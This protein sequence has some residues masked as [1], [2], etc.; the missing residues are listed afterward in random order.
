MN[1]KDEMDRKTFELF[2]IGILAFIIIMAFPLL[3]AI[4][5]NKDTEETKAPIV[6]ETPIAIKFVIEHHS[7]IKVDVKKISTEG[8]LTTYKVSAFKE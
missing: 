1:I 6:R 4:K 2:M 7:G 5:D 3:Y 8:N